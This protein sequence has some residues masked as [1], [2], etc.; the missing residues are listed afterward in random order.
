MQ[1]SQIHRYMYSLN[2]YS[3]KYIFYTIQLILQ[4]LYQLSQG[5]SRFCRVDIYISCYAHM[6]ISGSYE[7]LRKHFVART[8][9]ATCL[10]LSHLHIRYL[11]T[12]SYFFHFRIC[13][14]SLPFLFKFSVK[15]LLCNIAIFV[16]ILCKIA[17]MQ[18]FS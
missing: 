4:Y 15:L 14:H 5:L 12:P 17:S 6:Y 9:N 13:L 2:T 8:T 10:S 11:W 3:N 7:N 1:F 16:Q 18:Y